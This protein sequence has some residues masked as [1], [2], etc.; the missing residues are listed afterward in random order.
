MTEIAPYGSWKSPITS[1]VAAAIPRSLV[2]IAVDGSDIYWLESRPA[3]AGR[4]AILRHKVDRSIGECTPSDFSVRSTVHEYGGGAFTVSEGIVYFVNFK[5]QQLYRQAAGE[6]PRLLTRTAGCRYADL[7]VDLARNRL[8]CVREDHTVDG[9]AINTIVSVDADA[10]SYGL[11]LVGGNDFYASPRLS[12]DGKSLAYLTWN[13]PNMP[14]DGCELWIAELDQGGALR[15][16]RRIA[17][18]PTES[19]FQPEWSPGGQLYFVSDRTGWWNLYRWDGSQT[20]PLYPM[21][22]EFGRSQFQFGSSTYG[23]VSASRIMCS[24]SQNGISHL[25][26]FDP[27]DRRL[28]VLENAYTDVSEVRCGNGFAVFIAG[29][30]ER[31]HAV[32]RVDARTSQVETLRSSFEPAIPRACFSIPVAMDFPTDAG[33]KSHGFYY[34]PTNPEYAGP[35]GEHPP[36]VVMCHSGP[37]SATTTGLRYAIQFWTSRGFAVFDVNYGGSTGF[38]RA[39]RE[40]LR[41]QWGVVDVNDCC[42]GALF[43]AE[44]GLADRLR[45]AIRGSSAGGYTTLAALAFRN[46]VFHAGASLYGLADLERSV[47]QTHKFESR[48]L[49]SLIGPYPERRDLYFDRSPI[50]FLDNF[51]CPLILFQG[52]EDRIVPPSQSQML[53]EALR[54]RG[55][56]VAYML[57]Q[58][59][60]HGFRQAHNI[61]RALEAELYF[62]SRIFGFTPADTIEPIRIENL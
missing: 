38:G 61:R 60:E 48:Y 23:F 58:G 52:D 10:S 46:S 20:Q 15:S 13:H 47:H 4:C 31:P 51:A 22:A 24:Y 42:N 8:I 36:L 39:Y 2:T 33:L 37:T 12:P 17:G 29:S 41:G 49:S 59:E 11:V 19:V 14:W 30:P 1:E 5:D 50:H 16:A 7:V 53:F 40:R 28:D 55:L 21:E 25:A 44:A 43:L 6:A 45:L 27:E 62:Y 54:A 9:E 35:P 3:E 56:P 57:F 32:A 26:W 34:G 18:S